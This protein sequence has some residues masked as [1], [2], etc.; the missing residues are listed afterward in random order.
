MPGSGGSARISDRCWVIVDRWSL[1][2]CYNECRLAIEFDRQNEPGLSQ[3]RERSVNC[4]SRSFPLDFRRESL[5]VERAMHGEYRLHDRIF[6]NSSPPVARQKLSV[7]L[8][9]LCASAER[10]RCR[11][12]VFERR[13]RIGMTPATAHG[14]STEVCSVRKMFE[15]VAA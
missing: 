5:T 13:Y 2:R 1:K 7:S 15:A 4:N 11:E 14:H 9:G 3:P 12:G 10:W 8:F 6:L